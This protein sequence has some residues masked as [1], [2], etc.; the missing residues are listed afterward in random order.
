[1]KT[2]QD[3]Y[4]NLN[5]ILQIIILLLGS[6]STFAATL[7]TALHMVPAKWWP[8]ASK[9]ADTAGIW[10]L[11][12]KDASDYISKLLSKMG[13]GGPPAAA[14]LLIAFGLTAGFAITGCPAAAVAPAV[15]A[16]TCE[17]NLVQQHLSFV[18]FLA[19][20]VV[21]CGSD[22]LAVVASVLAKKEPALAV[23]YDEAVA[24]QND[25]AKMQAL[26]AHVEGKVSAL[27]SA[28]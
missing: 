23:Y 19:Q 1:M 20:S 10:G 26:K 4:D 22:W 12:L 14:A 25:P 11:H 5:P 2:I 21:Q 7:Q 15:I 17:Y 13:K 18:D 9:A 28:K 8:N 24:A 3:I 6:L 27:R 16:G